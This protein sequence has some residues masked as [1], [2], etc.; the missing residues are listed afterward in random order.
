[1]FPRP[2]TL[3]ILLG[4]LA[5]LALGCGT[6][7]IRTPVFKEGVI[8]S[9]LRR[10]ESGGQTLERRFEHPAVIAPVRLTHLLAFVDVEVPKGK[11]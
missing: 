5:P 3:A 9:Y 8:E 6:R 11:K 2:W 4:I 10:Y 7:V 1:M